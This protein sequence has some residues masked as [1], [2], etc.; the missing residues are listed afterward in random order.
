MQPGDVLARHRGDLVSAEFGP[1]MAFDKP[2][3]LLRR[4]LSVP[5]RDMF[6]E[7]AIEQLG[8]GRSLTE[9]FALRR[10]ISENES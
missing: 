7:I 9:G 1:D 6:G 2:R 4:A 3:H 8:Y 10:R 5:L